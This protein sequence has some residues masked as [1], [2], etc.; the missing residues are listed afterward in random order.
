VACKLDGFNFVGLE[1]DPEYTKIAQA[2]INNYVEN[3]NDYQNDIQENKEPTINN[4]D[5]TQLALF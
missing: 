3:P 5:E 4:E 1:Q 2:R